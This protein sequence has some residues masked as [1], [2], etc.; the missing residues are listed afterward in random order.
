MDVV[1]PLALFEHFIP[2]FEA[3]AIIANIQ[4][5]DDKTNKVRANN[6]KA[7]RER[8]TDTGLEAGSI[9]VF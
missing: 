2:G 7:Y 3:D 6:I 5:N 8:A 1:S 4:V 9:A